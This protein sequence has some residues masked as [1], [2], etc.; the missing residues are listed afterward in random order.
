VA[1]SVQTLIDELMR[2]EHPANAR[3]AAEKWF[4]AW[5]KYA[6]SMKHLAGNGEAVAKAPFIR[7]LKLAFVGKATSPA[8]F[9]LYSSAMAA[10]WVALGTP[11]TLLQDEPVQNMYTRLSVNPTLIPLTPTITPMIEVM[12]RGAKSNKRPS[13]EFLGRQVHAWTKTFTVNAQVYQTSSNG[14]ILVPTAPLLFG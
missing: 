10:A 12:G 6:R 13:R 11:A 5:W 4:A 8:F 2:L 3:E 7:I 1:L 9:S 14:L